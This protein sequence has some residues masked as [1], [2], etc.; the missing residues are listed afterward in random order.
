MDDAPETIWADSPEIFD[1]CDI[2]RDNPI[3]P[4]AIKYR[5]ADLPATDAQALANPKVQALVVKAKNTIKRWESPNW[6][7]TKH[8][9]DYISELK[10][11]LEAIASPSIAAL[12]SKADALQENPDD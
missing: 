7:D 3:N 2:W 11:A 6:K 1:G 5:R 12:G 4:K 10:A 8:T 9:G